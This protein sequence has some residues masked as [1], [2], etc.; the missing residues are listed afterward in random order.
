MVLLFLSTR[1]ELRRRRSLQEERPAHHRGPARR[2]C[3]Y[4]EEAGA[5]EAVQCCPGPAP[6]PGLTTV[7]ALA[8]LA[9][10]APNR[11]SHLHPAEPAALVRW[12]RSAPGLAVVSVRWRWVGR[13]GRQEGYCHTLAVEIDL[14]AG[15][16]G[17]GETAQS[18]VWRQLGTGPASSCITERGT[19]IKLS[20]I[21]QQLSLTDCV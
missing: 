6:R 5:G 12:I 1:Q 20:R 7:H 18:Q 15:Q 13:A 2:S 16:A 14:G 10:P 4:Q 17:A 19:I 8:T 21:H 9:T 11:S 3:S